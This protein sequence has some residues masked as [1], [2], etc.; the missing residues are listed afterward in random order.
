M[1][2]G[3]AYSECLKIN[4][5]GI[6]KLVQIPVFMFRPSSKLPWYAAEK[7]QLII[8]INNNN[9]FRVKYPQ[10]VQLT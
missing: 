9:L 10:C 4:K 5:L 1:I 2:V 3:A 8:I 6:V 7:Y